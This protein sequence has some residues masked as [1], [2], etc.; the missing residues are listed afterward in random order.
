MHKLGKLFYFNSPLTRTVLVT[1]QFQHFTCDNINKGT[2]ASGVLVNCDRL[3]LTIIHA[4]ICNST[5]RELQIIPNYETQNS[6]IYAKKLT[7]I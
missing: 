3:S 6:K 1:A 5:S 4:M 7:R 2:C